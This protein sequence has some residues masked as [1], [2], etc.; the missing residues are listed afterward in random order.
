MRRIVA[1]VFLCAIAVQGLAAQDWDPPRRWRH[2]DGVQIRVGRNYHLPADQIA[3]WP[4]VVIGAS[5][6]IDGRVEDDVVVIG[7]PVRIGPQAQIRANVVSL[8]GAVEVA[9]TAEV[10]G[11][12]HDIGVLWPEMSFAFRD[13]FW[14]IDRGWWAVLALAGT[15]FRY[16]LTLI[17]ACLLALVAQPWIRRIEERVSGAPLAAGFVGLAG[18]VLIVPAFAIVIGGLVLTIVGIPLLLLVPFAALALLVT[19]LVGFVSVAAFLGRLFRGRS[20]RTADP[21][22]VDVAWGVTLLLALPIASRLLAL[23]PGFL[24]PLSTALGLAGFV[25]EYLAWTVGLGAALLAPLHRRWQVGPPPLPTAAS[26]N[27]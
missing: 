9:D 6:T 26:V 22:V 11:E 27:A 10:T 2:R 25:L 7:G 14:G 24:W 16:A 15:V 1:A 8:G 12:I 19:W 23:A 5:A 3:S 20:R 13:W 18:E 4:I 21:T 17:A